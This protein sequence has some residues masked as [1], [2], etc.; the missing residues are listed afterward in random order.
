M[1]EI[2][3]LVT[4]LRSSFVQYFLS[5]MQHNLSQFLTDVTVKLE[6]TQLDDLRNSLSPMTG[7]MRDFQREYINEI[8]DSSEKLEFF[9]ERYCVDR[10]VNPYVNGA[11]LN[12]VCHTI[13]SSSIIDT[14]KN[15]KTT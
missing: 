4:V 7:Q 1:A 10:E 2:V 15:S 8:T 13:S 12:L 3:T 6:Q 14:R 11:N 9:H 5:D